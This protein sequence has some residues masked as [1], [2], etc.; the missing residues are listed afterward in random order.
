MAVYS[1]AKQVR[2]VFLIELAIL[3]TALTIAFLF[4]TNVCDESLKS[5]IAEGLVLGPVSFFLLATLR[6]LIF[7]PFIFVALVSGDSFGPIGGTIM[8]AITAVTSCLIVFAITK[9]VGKKMANP[10]LKSNLP[11]TLTFIRS[12][13]YK[14][15][16]ALRLIP[17]LPFDLLSFAF[18]ALD[19]R[20]KS[21]AIATFFG[22]L[23]E[24]YLYAHMLTPNKT[25]MS[26]T[27]VTLST[28]AACIIGS[29]LFLEFISRRRGK[30]LWASSRAMYREITYEV[31]TNND[32]VKRYDFD[33]NK[34]AV[35]L[36]YG[37]FSSRRALTVLERMLT[38]R[39]HQVF[40]FNLGGLFGTFFTKGIIETANFVDYKIRRQVKKYG[41]KEFQVVAHSKGGLVALWWVLKLG[42][43]KYCKKIITMGTPFV[44][45]KYTYLALVTPLGFF[46]RDVWQMRPGSE[47]LKSIKE[48]EIPQGVEIYCLHS[49]ADKVS[50][51]KKGIFLSRTSPGSVRPIALNHISHFEFLYRK[52]VS[53]VISQIL[54]QKPGENPPGKVSSKIEDLANQVK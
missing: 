34:T 7:T 32:I 10:W 22:V 40:S 52:D 18:G 30:G 25:L 12:Q 51:G 44:G 45:T 13:D 26:S 27:L 53:D 4:W 49:E 46:W 36:L 14:I 8:T 16:F 47:F 54:N 24:A 37:F 31:R 1:Y 33:P 38:Q 11:A 42:G 5:C 17:V 21:V 15:V 35:L 9:V 43:S 3:L 20:F 19:F 29:L 2:A 41:I 23:P 6:P 48:A 50:K 28:I 39:G